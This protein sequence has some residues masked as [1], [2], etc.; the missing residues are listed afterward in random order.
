VP[1]LLLVDAD[2]ESLGILDATPE[3]VRGWRRP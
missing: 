1:S 2:G 3:A